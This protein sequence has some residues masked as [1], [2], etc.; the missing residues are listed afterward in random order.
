MPLLVVVGAGG[1]GDG[2]PLSPLSQSVTRSLA[3][4]CCCCFF[5]PFPLSLGLVGGGWWGLSVCTSEWMN[6]SVNKGEESGRSIP[7]QQRGEFGGGGSSS[8]HWGGGACRVCACVHT[9]SCCPNKR[10]VCLPLPSPSSPR[11]P[12]SQARFSMQP[13]HAESSSH[14][15]PLHTQCPVPPPPSPPSPHRLHKLSDQTDQQPTN[16]RIPRL[17]CSC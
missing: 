1:G 14:T 3:A 16:Q 4:A 15:P 7:D 10:T 6:R 13:T 8:G 12:T 2:S 17:S 5:P 9:K 11:S